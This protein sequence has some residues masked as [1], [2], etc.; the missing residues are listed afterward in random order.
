[1]KKTQGFTLIELMIVIAII[2][3]L[4]AIAI[5]SYNNY[6]KTSKMGAVGSNVKAA[7]SIIGAEFSKFRA[8]KNTPNLPL[9]KYPLINGTTMANNAGA[10]DWVAFLMEK[11]QAPSPEVQA[12]NGFAATAVDNDGVIGIGATV[13]NTVTITTPAYLDL[14]TVNIVINGSD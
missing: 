11:T 13:N 9:T 7:Q 12:N 2:G 8:A 3:I 5:P 10:A 6:I 1:M 14:N 4:A